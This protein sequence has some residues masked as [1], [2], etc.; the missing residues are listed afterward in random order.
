[1]TTAT[2]PAP[3]LDFTRPPETFLDVGHARLAYRRLGSGPDLLLLH[4]WPVSSA[5]FHEIAPA[6]AERFTCHLIDLPGAGHTQ[7]D[8]G[9]PISIAGHSETVCRAVESLGLE[10]YALV[11]HDSGAAIGRYAAARAPERLVAMVLGNTEI[12]GYTP[13]LLTRLLR[14]LRLPGGQA[15]FRLALRIGVLRRSN[16]GLGTA[17]A[18]R[19]LLDG[20][21]YEH[22]IAP[23]LRSREAA[24]GQ[25][26]LLDGFDPSDF[27]G[28]VE[29][30]AAINAPVQLIWGDADPWFPLEE[31][32]GMLPQFSGGAELQ[33]LPG[34]KVFA[35]EEFAA[36]FVGHALPF[37]ERA[38][39]RGGE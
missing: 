20:A 29:A 28:L 7:W 30:H 11:A 10:R 31:A 13:P 18:D 4:G 3:S 23:I 2:T 27:D 33:I 1:M 16:L 22:A 35:H 24:A 36:E 6:L 21:F 12:P 15:V 17:F 34:G 9:T 38:F 32:R 5:T 25:M 39:A 19:S 26:A 14:L 8:A 37:L